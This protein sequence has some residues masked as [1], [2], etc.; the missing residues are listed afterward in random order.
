MDLIFIRTSSVRFGLKKLNYPF[1]I[2]ILLTS[3]ERDA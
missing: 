2:E 3:I 1:S